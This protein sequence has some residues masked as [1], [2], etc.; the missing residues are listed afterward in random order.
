MAVKSFFQIFVES[1]KELIKKPAIVLPSLVLWGILYGLSYLGGKVAYSFDLTWENIVWS[2]GFWIIGALVM[3]FV[4]AGMIGMALG[5][6]FFGNGRKFLF[7]NFVI[8]AVILIASIITG[9]VAHYVAFVIGKALNLGID[10]ARFLFML[11]Y[12]FGLIGFLIFLTFSSFFLVWKNLSVPESIKA[13][14]KFVKRNYLSVLS[15]SVVIFVVF[16]LVARVT[17]VISELLE[18]L[19]LVPL[20]VLIFTKF[21]VSEK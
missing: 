15:L 13:S 6:E 2:V 19:I 18:Y 4:F 7:R 17:E 9:R 8:L 16:F 5:K 3:G 10:P 1:L 20:S 11:V 21:M 12:L 14:V